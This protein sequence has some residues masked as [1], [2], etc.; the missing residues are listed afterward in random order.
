M[1]P[2]LLLLTAFLVTSSVAAVAQCTPSEKKQI[3]EI[4]DSWITN[5]N[6]KKLDDV[7]KLYAADATYLPSDGSRVIGLSDIQAFFEKVVNF[8]ASADSVNLECSG[9]LAY[10]SGT[11]I[12]EAIG[13]GTSILPGSTVSPNTAVFADKGKRIEG[14]YLVV[15]KHGDGKWLIVQHASTARPQI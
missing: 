15:L 3:A 6:A 12:Q 13:G 11:Y 1:K 7:I 14:N 5:W 9:G 10:D 4:R 2:L 8:K